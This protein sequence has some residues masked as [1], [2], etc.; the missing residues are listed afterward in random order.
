M[1][2]ASEYLSFW[3]LRLIS[4]KEWTV[5]MKTNRGCSLDRTDLSAQQEA[6]A[7][8]KGQSIRLCC[9]HVSC[10]NATGWPHVNRYLSADELSCKLDILWIHLRDHVLGPLHAFSIFRLL[11]CHGLVQIWSHES[12]C[13]A[14]LPTVVDKWCQPDLSSPSQPNAV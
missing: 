10:T 2:L 14:M 9:M 4:D 3:Y 13:W 8:S 5:S 12:F 1:N 11:V 7:N 6:S